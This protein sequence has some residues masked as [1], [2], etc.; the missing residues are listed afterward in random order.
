MRLI[1]HEISRAVRFVRL[2]SDEHGPRLARAFMDRYE[3][4]QGPA[5]VEQYDARNGILFRGGSF[6]KQ[7][8]DRFQ[9]YDIGALAEA[10]TDTQ[11]LD[12]FLDDAL[13]WA[14]TEWG[15]QLLTDPAPPI[16]RTY[17]SQLILELEP[18]ATQ[19]TGSTVELLRTLEEALERGGVPHAPIGLTGFAIGPDPASGANWS[20]RFER[21]LG[22]PFVSNK[23]YSSAPLT[24]KD[25]LAVLEKVQT[26]F[27][28]QPSA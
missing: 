28:G 20:F 14:K 1:E 23:A 25:H 16:A 7:V 22:E 8:I 5:T 24:T 12:D 26:I 11:V 6:R 27:T 4:M 9:L 21:R 15:L 2:Q 17:L 19:P 10:K 18:T 13:D 3:F